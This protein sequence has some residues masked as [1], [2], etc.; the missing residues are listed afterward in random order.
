[1]VLFWNILPAIIVALTF[2][3]VLRA[4]K[5]KV[6]LW[7]VGIAAA[8]LI[9]L[10]MAQ[11]SYLPKGDIQRSELPAFEPSK[12]QIEDRNRKPVDSEIRDARQK[13]QY[14]LGSPALNRYQ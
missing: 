1:M 8:L 12:A 4:K 7:T 6:K 9:L 5:S 14:E 3:V 11:P 2:F 13:E 10:Q